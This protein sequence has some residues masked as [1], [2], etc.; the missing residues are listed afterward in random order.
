M[1]T[2]RILLP[3][4]LGDHF[5]DDAPGQIKIL[6]PA[7]DLW[8]RKMHRAKAQWWLS[9]ILHRKEELLKVLKKKLQ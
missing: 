9:A 7:K 8:Q 6:L 3:D 4:Q 5:I 1:A 2:I